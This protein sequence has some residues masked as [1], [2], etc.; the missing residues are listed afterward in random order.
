M[1]SRKWLVSAVL[2]A[3]LGVSC[4][5]GCPAESLTVPSDNAAAQAGLAKYSDT[6]AGCHAVSWLK[7]REARITADLAAEHRIAGF[8]LTNEE[9]ANLRAFLATQ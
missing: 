4:L 1:S 8:S 7:A 9:A 6:C 5:G 2:V 3:L